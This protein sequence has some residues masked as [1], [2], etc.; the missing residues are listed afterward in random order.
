MMIQIKMI[1][2]KDFKS[3]KMVYMQIIWWIGENKH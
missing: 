1:K 2:A 3:S